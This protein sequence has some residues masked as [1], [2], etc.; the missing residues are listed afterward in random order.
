M[1]EIEI[2]PAIATDIHTLM[3]IDHTYS[4][5]YVWQMEIQTEEKSIGVNL[6]EIRLPR[7]VRVEYPRP[8]HSLAD[9]WTRRSGLL[10]SVLDSEV[11]G[12]ISLMLDIAPIT[13][14]V[15]DLAVIRRVRRQGIGSALVLAAQEWGEQHNT[16]RIVLELQPKNHS[17][18]LMA[19]KLGFTFCGYN[20]RF[21]ANHDIGLF[22][23]KSL[24]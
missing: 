2:R 22:F 24:R 7:S 19:Q 23:A 15:T 9:D 1:P 10:V 12:Y 3:A 21:Y 6:R 14:W 17:A 11:V 5:D 16:R 13:T 18:I 4:S 20:D 8:T